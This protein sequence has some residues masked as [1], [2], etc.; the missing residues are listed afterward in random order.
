MLAF[1]YLLAAI[2]A[3][4]NQ[5]AVITPAPPPAAVTVP[6][7]PPSDEVSDP[8]RKLVGKEKLVAPLGNPGQWVLSDDYPEGALQQNRVGITGF[9]LQIN[10]GGRV[11]GC[12]ITISSGHAD[13]DVATCRL[14]AERAVFSPERD[15]NGRAIESTYEN[16]VRWQIPAMPVPSP[17]EFTIVYTVETDGTVRNCKTTGSTPDG[18]DPCANTITFVPPVDRFGNPVRKQIIYSS[19]TRVGILADQK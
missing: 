17:S 3:S 9:R 5:D 7:P 18:S 12:D 1:I 8:I 15:R 6:L 2:G 14:V 10:R 11:T 16:R 13:L 19:V 4:G